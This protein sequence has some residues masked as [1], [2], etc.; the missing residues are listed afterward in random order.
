[1]NKNSTGAKSVVSGQEGSGEVTDTP[2][3]Y[4]VSNVAI[5]SE[6]TVQSFV[7]PPILTL[8]VR[9]EFVGESALRYVR[10]VLLDVHTKNIHLTSYF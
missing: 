1:V 5:S 9:K 2:T 8:S 3:P 4:S 7:T 10:P 6:E